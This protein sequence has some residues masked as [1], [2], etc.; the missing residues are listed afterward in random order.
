MIVSIL[1]VDIIQWIAADDYVSLSKNSK[2][3]FSL[4]S[5]I[6]SGIIMDNNNLFGWANNS[7]WQS[8]NTISLNVAWQFREEPQLF[9]QIY[10][11]AITFVCN[12]KN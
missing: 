2:F 8:L 7:T 6:D 10:S 11:E 12:K 5:L 1:L 4:L 3:F 9:F